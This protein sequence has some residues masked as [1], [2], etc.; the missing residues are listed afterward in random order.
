[1]AGEKKPWLD[2]RGRSLDFVDAV[3]EIVEIVDHRMGHGR[4]EYRWSGRNGVGLT[5][6]GR[7]C[8]RTWKNHEIKET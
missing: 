6:H 5:I 4:A 3:V 7:Y 1:M 8:G 2:L